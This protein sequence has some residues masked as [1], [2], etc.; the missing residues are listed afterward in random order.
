[1][2]GKLW[3]LPHEYVNERRV[4]CASLAGQRDEEAEGEPVHSEDHLIAE[5][6]GDDPSQRM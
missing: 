1:M 6:P 4:I 2:C 3:K 5:P